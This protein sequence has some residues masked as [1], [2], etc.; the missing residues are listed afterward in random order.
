MIE[1]L[2][3]VPTGK[4]DWDRWSFHHR[5][6]HD[7]IR[8]AIATRV[9]SV[10][11]TAAGSG[12]TDGTYDLSFSGSGSGASG[13]YTVSGGVVSSLSLDTNGTG[14]S[15]AP[16]VS[17]PS[18][19]GSGASATALLDANLTAYPLDPIPAD[20]HQ[21]LIWNQQ[22]HNDMNGALGLQSSDLQDADFTKADSVKD[23][24]YLHFLEHQTAALELGI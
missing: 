7:Q 21:W 16:T 4:I 9:G 18:G 13:T 24:I 20:T 1:V 5:D 10:T 11:L 22:T 19:G 6:H 17:F 14:Y 23:W 8:A 15:T 12:Y 3:E 2:M